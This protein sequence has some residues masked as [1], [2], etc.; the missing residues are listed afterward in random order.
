MVVQVFDNYNVMMAF[1]YIY[2]A[3]VRCEDDGVFRVLRLS[4]MWC[5]TR[6]DAC[7]ST[8]VTHLGAK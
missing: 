1:K 4:I 2:K 3:A 8:I 7:T 6:F 5:T